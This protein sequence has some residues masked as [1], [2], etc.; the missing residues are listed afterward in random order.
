[1]TY[2]AELINFLEDDQYSIQWKYSEDGEEFFD[3]EGANDLSYEYAI[4]KANAD[5]TWRISIVLITPV[6]AEE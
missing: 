3:I 1:M 6:T 5:Y 2:E 4:T